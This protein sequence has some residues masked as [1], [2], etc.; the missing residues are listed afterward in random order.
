MRTKRFF[1]LLITLLL[2][3]TVYSQSYWELST[4]YPIIIGVGETRIVSIPIK[5]EYELLG[6]SISG[7][8]EIKCVE[9]TLFDLAI[10]GVKEG[11]VYIRVEREYIKLGVEITEIVAY[12]IYV[13]GRIEIKSNNIQMQ[14]GDVKSLEISTS[15]TELS[16]YIIEEKLFIDYGTINAIKYEGNGQVRAV[17]PGKVQTFAQVFFKDGHCMYSNPCVISVLPEKLVKKIYLSPTSL[18]F[19]KLGEQQSITAIVDPQDAS[20]PSIEWISSNEDV[21]TVDQS[22]TVTSVSSGKATIMAKATDGSGTKATC[23]VTVDIKEEE[24]DIYMNIYP[25]DVFGTSRGYTFTTEIGSAQSAPIYNNT[26]GLQIYKGGKMTINGLGTMSNIIFHLS[27]SMPL[28]TADVGTIEND[29]SDNSKVI[30]TGSASTVTF[31]VESSNAFCFKYFSVANSEMVTNGEE[32]YLIDD[33]HA[34]L[35]SISPSNEAIEI[36]EAIAKRDGNEIRVHAVIGICA[37]ACRDVKEKFSLVLPGNIISIGP[38]AFKGCGV[39]QLE[40][41]RTQIERIEDETFMDCSL[42][43]VSIPASVTSIGDNAFAGCLGLRDIYC[44]AENIPS[45]GDNTFYNTWSAS[46]HV[47]AVSFNAYLETEPWCNFTYIHPIADDDAIIDFADVNVKAI[48][49]TYW[50]T[51]GDGELSKKEAAAVTYLGKIFKENAD[52]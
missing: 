25:T 16:K 15:P 11:W 12:A 47:P 32:Y 43:S 14:V 30:W 51:N 45:T 50:D 17:G 33:G 5:L 27:N 22:G 36:P 24:E 34:W 52:H 18:E 46:L 42:S 21:A 6:W 29:P 2:V 19:H 48:C 8:G 23:S 28:I 10:T 1:I 38:R 31:T 9:K 49:V 13:G 20:I 26:Y 39:K 44:Y 40:L 3:K 7:P 35:C 41:K 37:D 4:E